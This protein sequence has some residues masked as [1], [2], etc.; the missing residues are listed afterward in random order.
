MY[1]KLQS[2]IVNIL[3]LSCTDKERIRLSRKLHGYQRRETFLFIKAMLVTQ[4]RLELQAYLGM[5]DMLKSVLV[6]CFRLQKFLVI[7]VSEIRSL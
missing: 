2:K 4:E 1:T 5:L 3:S 6:S 7:L